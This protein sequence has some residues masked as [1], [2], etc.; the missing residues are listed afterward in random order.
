M[1]KCKRGA[2]KAVTPFAENFK[3]G[4]KSKLNRAKMAP[5]SKPKS[6]SGKEIQ[7]NS[8]SSGNWLRS[9]VLRKTQNLRPLNAN[10][11]HAGVMVLNPR[12]K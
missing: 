8:A 11:A 9:Q 3:L 1:V 12:A 4:I 2:S 7:H 5:N 6:N 10:S